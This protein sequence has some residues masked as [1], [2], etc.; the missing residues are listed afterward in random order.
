MLRLVVELVET[1]NKLVE[2]AIV[3]Q[4]SYILSIT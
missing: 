2:T 1:L 3:F 4:V